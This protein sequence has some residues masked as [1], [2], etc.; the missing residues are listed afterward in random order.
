MKSLLRLANKRT[1]SE[2]NIPTKDIVMFDRLVGRIEYYQAEE[3]F[4]L[5]LVHGKSFKSYNPRPLDFIFFQLTQVEIKVDPW[6]EIT[7]CDQKIGEIV[8]KEP[9]A[10]SSKWIGPEGRVYPHTTSFGSRARYPEVFKSKSDAA[11]VAVKQFI[12]HNFPEASHE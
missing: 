10:F 2:I 11:F 8:R 5:V 7:W 1:L 12:I 3:P 4:C 6:G 9:D